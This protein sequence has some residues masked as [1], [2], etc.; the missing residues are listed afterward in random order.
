MVLG[1][2]ERPLASGQLLLL[3]EERE[4]FGLV[5]PLFFCKRCV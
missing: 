5:P 1:N 2:R 3:P 4:R